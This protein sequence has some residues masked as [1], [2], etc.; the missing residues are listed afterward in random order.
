VSKLS[1]GN[2]LYGFVSAKIGLLSKNP[3]QDKESSW[4]R[5]MLAKLRR[6]VGKTPGSV[7]EIWEITV[8]DIPDGWRSEEGEPS[9]AESAIH[10]ALTLYAVHQQGRSE[11]MSVSGKDENGKN[12]GSSFGG[13]V[14]KLI[15]PNKDNG[16]AV[17][18]RFNA[19]ATASDFTEL[20]HH[21][22]GLIQ[23]LKAEDIPMDYPRFA[24]DLFYFQIPDLANGVR[25]RWGEDFYRAQRDS[26]DK[27]ES[28]GE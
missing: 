21:A 5:A 12:F 3:S 24:R 8:G 9:E 28:G 13:A 27:T 6:G 20:A 23:L 1:E 10:T 4:S 17:M 25:L 11:P 22:R 14:A 2:R 26:N 7:P 19:V 16:Q 18:R 15:N